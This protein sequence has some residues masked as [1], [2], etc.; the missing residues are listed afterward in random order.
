MLCSKKKKKNLLGISGFFEDPQKSQVQIL[1]DMSV[2]NL[3]MVAFDFSIR[4]KILVLRKRLL[5]NGFCFSE[6]LRF[7][8]PN[9]MLIRFSSHPHLVKLLV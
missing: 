8:S 2:L 7:Y 6:C 5:I 4:I 1:C 9:L 3:V